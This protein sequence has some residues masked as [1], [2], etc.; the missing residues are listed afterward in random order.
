MGFQLLR[1]GEHLFHVRPGL[2][3]D[4]LDFLDEGVAVGDEG[5]E[6]LPVIRSGT[7]RGDQQVI[8]AQVEGRG[9]FSLLT[10]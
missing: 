9:L 2:I 10:F 6:A 7:V 3:A 4:G 5:L 1:C 8:V